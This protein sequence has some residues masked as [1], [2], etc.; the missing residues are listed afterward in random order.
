MEFFDKMPDVEVGDVVMTSA[1]SQLFPAGMPIGRV[2]E[3][4]LNNS[5]AP[6][7]TIELSAPIGLLEW[8]T[9]TPFETPETLEIPDVPQDEAG[10]WS[11]QAEDEAD[12]PDLSSPAI[13][14]TP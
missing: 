6:E 3:L 8:V 7:V 5:P 2:V 9:V 14:E 10:N 4:N 12:S 1:Y 11:D 13:E